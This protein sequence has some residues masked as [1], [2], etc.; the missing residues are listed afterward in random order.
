M[1]V[2]DQLT[3][4]IEPRAH[5]RQRIVHKDTDRAQRMIGRHEILQLCDCEQTFLHRVGTSHRCHS[6]AIMATA[7]TARYARSAAK[8]KRFST[9]C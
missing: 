6:E 3:R 7:S 9:A 8:I 1:Q 5:R 2:H 4:I